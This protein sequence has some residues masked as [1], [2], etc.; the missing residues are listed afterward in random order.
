MASTATYTKVRADILTPHCFICH[1]GGNHD[2]STYNGLKTVVVAGKPE[3]SQLYLEVNSGAMPR[4]G[5]KLSTD[6]IKLIYDWIKAG[7][8]NN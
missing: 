8:L 6:E 3:N 4:G 5:Q 2:F 7:A 1:G